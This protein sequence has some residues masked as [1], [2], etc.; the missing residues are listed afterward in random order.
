MSVMQISWFTVLKNRPPPSSISVTLLA[1]SRAVW[2]LT[3]SGTAMMIAIGRLLSGEDPANFRRAPAPSGR[4]MPSQV[5]CALVQAISAD[6]APISRACNSQA[7]DVAA[8]VSRVSPTVML[9]ARQDQMPGRSS[10]RTI[11]SRANAVFS[12]N[13]CNSEGPN[14]SEVKAL[15]PK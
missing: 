9:S 7:A 15:L 12:V 2:F 3:R 10:A 4:G 11:I 14:L 6:N 8:A 1:N 5:R 13:A